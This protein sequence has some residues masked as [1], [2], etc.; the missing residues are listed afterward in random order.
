MRRRVALGF[1]G[2][3]L[4]ALL[5]I[6]GPLITFAQVPTQSYI[7][8]VGLF[9]LSDQEATILFQYYWEENVPGVGGTIAASVPATL[10]G[11]TGAT[12]WAEAPDGFVGSLVIYSDQTL[13]AQSNVNS[14][15]AG[16]N[17]WASSEGF[18]E[19]AS[20]MYAPVILRNN[21]GFSSWFAVQNVGDED[22]TVMVDFR[23]GTSGNDDVDGPFDISPGAMMLFNQQTDDELG[24]NFV[25]AAV[26]S[27]TNAISLAATI[28]LENTTTQKALQTYQGFAEGSGGSTAAFPIILADNGSCNTA[29]Q[30]QNMGTA[31]TD[32]TVTYGPNEQ[33]PFAPVAETQYSIQPGDQAIFRQWVGQWSGTDRYVGSAMATSSGEPL[34]G[35]L[36]QL[37]STTPYMALSYSS[38]NPDAAT[39]KVIVPLAMCD[40]G[41]QY[42]AIQVQSVGAVSTLVTVDYQ[43]GP[44]FTY[45][46]DDETSGALSQGDGAI[47]RQ[48]VD[49]WT[50]P[51]KN[52]GQRWKGSAVVTSTGD[53]PIV[54]VVTIIQNPRGGDTLMAY[55]GT[56]V[57]P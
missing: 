31:A 34:V 41:D 20:T 26:I 8:S 27:S 39:S 11:N 21:G 35:V 48:W 22:A 19:G 29:I 1:A 13:N 2:G 33:G 23:A 10:A 46:P 49:Q 47:F 9:N 43:P 17:L 37:C 24:S 32:I 42:T 15:G 56:N 4:L 30:L 40:N 44:G 3:G 54:A 38:L 18:E 52:N 12:Y 14:A 7:S 36:N 57:E 53:V 51:A 50:D 6:V 16:T 25:G 55:N 28:N 45:E 5:L